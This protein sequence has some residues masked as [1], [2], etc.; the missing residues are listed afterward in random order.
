MNN[1]LIKVSIGIFRDGDKILIAQSK[2]KANKIVWEFPGGKNE[3]KETPE[4]T[5]YRELKE[6]LN[7]VVR[8]ARLIK[9]FLTNV[10][11][12]NYELS[13][14][15]VVEWMGKCIGLEGQVLKWVPI[16]ELLNY[17]MHEPN[18][19]I[20]SSLMLPNRIMITPFL[21]KD[22]ELFLENLDL[23][24]RH[25]IKLLQ[26][27]LTHDES[28]NKLISREV[29]KKS[30]DKVKIMINGGTSEFDENYFDGLH[31]P[32]NLARKLNV[33]PVKKKYLFSISC[34]NNKEIEHADLIDADFVYLSPVKKT[35]SHPNSN[36]LGWSKASK[37]AAA[38]SK[39]VYALGGLS[40]V[41]TSR[42]VENGFQGIAGITTFWN[43]VF[44]SN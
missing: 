4:Q 31:L 27:R 38:S 22:Y 14:F 10:D 2:K 9:R 34:H 3:K 30:G 11:G 33:R 12:S 44:R 8:K 35:T 25:K 29:K 15:S 37:I 24:E 17:N 20:F 6:E 23:L 16:S 18:K 32:F 26:L 13:I 39:P 40:I 21:D 42:A 19:K 1:F 28:T 36:C 41:D 7:V 5:L 43:F